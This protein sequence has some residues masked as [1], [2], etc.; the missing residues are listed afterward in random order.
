VDDVAELTELN[1]TFIEAFEKGSWETLQPVLSPGFSYID[2]NTGEVWGMDQYIADVRIGL[3]T[4][5]YDQVAIHVDGDAAVVSA[6]T[7][8]KPGRYNRYV[9]SYIK[10]DG[11]WMCYHACVWLL[12][13]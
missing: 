5:E 2:G 9:D 3:P 12:A 8:I 10:R 7:W 13:S 6:R 11:R 1:K 4:L